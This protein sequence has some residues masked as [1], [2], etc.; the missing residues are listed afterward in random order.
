MRVIR[1]ELRPHLIAAAT[2][3]L[4]AVLV[5]LPVAGDPARLALGHPGN[6]VWNHV[7]G[8]AWVARS[9]ADGELPLRA[10]A[11]QWPDGG[12]LWFIDTF[13]AVLTLPVQWAFGPVAA[14][15]TSIAAN[16][17]LCGFGAW[18]LALRV[19]NSPPGAWLAGVAYATVPQLL[20]QA[21]N[22][23]SETMAAGWLPLA[24]LAM[25]EAARAPSARSGALAGAVWAV[26]TIANWY[27]GLFAAM[28]ALGLFAR[29]AWRGPPPG[30]LAAVL[31]GGA[32]AAAIMAPPFVL[33][34]RSME[35]AD[36]LVSRDPAFNWMTLILHNMTDGL[37]LVH[38][39]KFYSPDL[40]A[41]FGED[42]IVVV[43]LGH[44]LL[45]PAL[46]GLLLARPRGVAVA[47]GAAA[48]VFLV[49]TLG[50][51]LYFGGDYVQV[52]GGWVP[53]PFL[54][55]FEWFP[56]FGRI[57]HAYR[58]AIGASLALA[59]LAAWGVRAAGQRGWRTV[60]LAVGLAV[61]RVF[62]SL[63]GSAAVWPVPASAL[64][65][66]AIYA[67]LDGGAIL[68]LPVGVPVLARSKYLA[69]QLVH[70]QPVPYGLN[71]PTP[72]YLYYN[73]FTQYLIELERSTITMLPPDLPWLDVELGRA[74]AVEDGLRWIV[75]H[76]DLYPGAQAEKIARFLDL[77]ATPVFDGEGLRVYRLD[78]AIAPVS[79]ADTGSAAALPT[80]TL[81]SAVR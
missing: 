56:M 81:P 48:A 52:A 14:Y 24:A 2:Y 6:D 10:A 58:F 54:A 4:L 19:T 77:Y 38:P 73:R 80:T 11:L 22:G 53:L 8:Y 79:R 72:P 67:E 47:W 3:A 40:K 23:I 46:A 7:W 29:A 70:E 55:L 71:D 25:R 59:V 12:S 21:Y 27:Y 74:A 32:V 76:R 78:A 15:N 75:V 28:L 44:V 69:Y 13:G 34:V 33:F 18:L 31:A 60:P 49:L 63:L 50:P 5:M 66:P 45:W 51:Y 41:T 68:D 64:E 61:A 9:L 26:A 36:A 16:L 39:G 43:Y 17:W 57:S 65:V 35:A 62:E 37:A 20:G 42:L 1:A 30:A